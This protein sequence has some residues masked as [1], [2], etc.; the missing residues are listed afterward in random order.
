MSILPSELARLN[1]IIEGLLDYS[2]FTDS[3]KE[4]LVLKRIIDETVALLKVEF[5][6]R[7]IS[8]TSNA[9]EELI[10]ADPKQLKQILINLLINAFEA[11]PEEGGT[12]DI[13]V[14]RTDAQVSLNIKDSGSGITPEALKMVFEPYYTTKKTGYGMGLA[15]TKQLVEENGGT[16]T[17]TSEGDGTLVNLSFPQYKQ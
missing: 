12:I 16:I 7:R 17:L 10:F 2:K 14:S 6:S 11:L 1:K 9:S 4:V 5:L 3:E 13:A 8:F 15:I